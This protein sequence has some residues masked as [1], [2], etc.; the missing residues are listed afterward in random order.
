[1]P[2]RKTGESIRQIPTPVQAPEPCPACHTV[3]TGSCPQQ[4]RAQSNG[5]THVPP[6]SQQ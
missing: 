3:H 1:M 5:A 6:N 4:K 2:F